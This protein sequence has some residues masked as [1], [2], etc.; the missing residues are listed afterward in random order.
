MSQLFTALT[1]C[2]AHTALLLNNARLSGDYS[3]G[4]QLLGRLPPFPGRVACKR[5]PSLGVSAAV[6]GPFMTSRRRLG[7]LPSQSDRID[8]QKVAAE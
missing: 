5:V 4:T 8:G 1:S 2:N 3:F 7:A 6:G